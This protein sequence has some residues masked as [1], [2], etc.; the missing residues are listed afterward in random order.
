VVLR[1]DDP[2]F[3]DDRATIAA[4]FVKAVTGAV[5]R[6]FS[7]N[8]SQNRLDED[9]DTIIFGVPVLALRDELYARVSLVSFA[10]SRAQ[11]DSN[12]VTGQFGPQGLPCPTSTPP[13]R[14]VRRRR[15]IR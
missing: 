5:N 6:T 8:V 14:P 10:S 13:S 12:V 4:T 7:S 11:S 15:P 9:G 3:D 2:I 1:G